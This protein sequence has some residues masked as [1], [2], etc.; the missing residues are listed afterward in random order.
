MFSP[1]SNTRPAPRSARLLSAVRNAVDL[2]VA[3]ATLESYDLSGPHGSV[4]RP[5]THPHRDRLRAPSRAGR[6]GAVPARAH[7]CVTPR[8]E[9]RPRRHQAHTTR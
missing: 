5:A 2:A 9:R 7:H 4:D 1:T 8:T 6:P 3:F